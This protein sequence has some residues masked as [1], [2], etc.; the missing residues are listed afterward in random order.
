M[1]YKPQ[2][3]AIELLFMGCVFLLFFHVHTNAHFTD[4]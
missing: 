1:M 2:L 3:V 4:I